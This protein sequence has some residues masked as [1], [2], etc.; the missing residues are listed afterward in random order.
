M[1][2]DNWAPMSRRQKAGYALVRLLGWMQEQVYRHVIRDYVWRSADGRCTPLREMEDGHLY[3]VLRMLK[4]ASSSPEKLR[5]IE[6]EV[7]RRM[8]ENHG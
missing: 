3:N 2:T 5:L 4:R 8:E 6:A 1:P 7:L